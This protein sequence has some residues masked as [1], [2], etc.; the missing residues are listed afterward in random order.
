MEI[1]SISFILISILLII[2]AFAFWYYTRIVALNKLIIDLV[3][4]FIVVK[5]MLYYFLPA[6]FRIYSGYQ[7]EIEDNVKIINL[8]FVYVVELVS[9]FFWLVVFFFVTYFLNKIKLKVNFRIKSNDSLLI[10]K[11]ILLITSLGFI[12]WNIFIFLKTY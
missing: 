7:F 3:F 1:F 11:Q 8:L 10:S 6:I 9:W 4:Y 2:Q 5:L 12:V